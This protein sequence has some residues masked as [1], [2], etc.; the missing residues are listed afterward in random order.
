MGVRVFSRMLDKSLACHAERSEASLPP[1][2]R[3]FGRTRTLPQSDI[4]SVPE[5]AM[6]W[7]YTYLDRG[8][9]VCY[10]RCHFWRYFYETIF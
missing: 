9:H 10:K 1:G 2:M 8:H 3:L 7:G 6:V 4:I 5:K